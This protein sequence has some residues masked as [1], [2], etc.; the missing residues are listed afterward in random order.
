LPAANT[1]QS[2]AQLYEASIEYSRNIDYFYIIEPAKGEFQ[3]I[4]EKNLKTNTK[5]CPLWAGYF[6]SPAVGTAGFGS[7]TAR[8][9]KG[10]ANKYR[11][12]VS[13]GSCPEPGMRAEWCQ[14][15][16]D[17]FSFTVL[18]ALEK[19]EN[20]NRRGIRGGYQNAF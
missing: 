5:K 19:K 3:W 1:I 14:Y 7:N 20:P 9:L 4:I 2:A 8:D 16:A 6:P 10:Q 18:E 13:T 12:A 17:S 11:F 15:G